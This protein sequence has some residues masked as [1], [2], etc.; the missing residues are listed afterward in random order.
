MTYFVYENLWGYE[1]SHTATI[2]FANCNHCNNGRGR[3]D[4]QNVESS[5]GKWHGP[6]YTFQDT[7]DAAIKTGWKVKYCRSCEP[8]W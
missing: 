4:V 7:K 2:H 5:F 3:N 8:D 6:F 1:H